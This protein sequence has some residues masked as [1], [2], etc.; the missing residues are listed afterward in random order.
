MRRGG[1]ALLPR[2]SQLYGRGCG[3]AFLA[4]GGSAVSAR[5]LRACCAA[6][7]APAG[8][9]EFTKRAFLSGRISLTQ[10]EA[11]MDLINA[12]SRQAAAAAAAAMEGALYAKIKSV[13]ENLVSLAGHI[14]AYTDY[15]EEDVP[16]LSMGALEASL[17][18]A[19]AA[20]DKLIAGYDAGAVLRR[21]CMQHC[22]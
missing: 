2:A 19:K 12:T 4:T 10:A 17:G 15:P 18:C 8:P 22:P 6:G 9:G 11:V 3:G 20:L 21:A 7:A 16:E 1:S 5:L 14:A 13:Q